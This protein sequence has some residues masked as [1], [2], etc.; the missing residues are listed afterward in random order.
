[1]FFWDYGAGEQ[2][3]RRLRSE[4]LLQSILVS[5]LASSDNLPGRIASEGD[6]L[7]CPELKLAMLVLFRQSEHLTAGHAANMLEHAGSDFVDGFASIDY[8]TRRKIEVARHA[9]EDG[10][11]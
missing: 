7:L 1:M 8:A 3:M 10:R 4:S 5:A 11:V 2:L 6:C 9:L